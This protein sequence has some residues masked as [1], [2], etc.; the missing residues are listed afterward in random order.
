[1]TTDGNH[2]DDLNNSELSQ[3]LS[4]MKGMKPP[5]SR[6][7]EEAW[8]LLMQSVAEQENP[9]PRVY[10]GNLRTWLAVA[11]SVVVLV[12]AG[13]SYFRFSTVESYCPRGQMAEMA[14]PDGSRVTLNADTKL[15]FPKFFSVAGRNIKLQ[16]EAY[17]RVSPGEKFT[18]TDSQHRMVEVVGTEFDVA[19][20]SETFRVVC[21][22]GTVNVSS[23]QV[24]KVKLGKGL[25]VE[26]SGDRLL[27]TKS[28]ADSIG[29]PSWIKGDFSFDGVPL[30]EVIAEMERQF[31]VQIVAEGFNANERT[32]TG[33][34][35]N[36]SLNE[37]LN[38]VTIP[39][40]L[41]FEVNPDS[42]IIK[43]HN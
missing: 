41:T 4:A 17:F 12:V 40:G 23:P 10:M 24:E 43:I 2:R 29:A 20:R 37:A 26:A 14:L 8:D 38:L 11:A 19:T 5:P 28:P 16:G 30:S 18:V 1:M 13:W 9:A 25:R 36:S 6:S 42:T 22:E 35:R 7:K 21:Y 33:F 32:Y 39:M 27:V 34:F 3:V 31:K 15:I